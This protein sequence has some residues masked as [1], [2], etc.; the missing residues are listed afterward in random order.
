MGAALRQ[1]LKNT[2]HRWCKWHVL[3]KLVEMLGHL[4]NKHKEF[5]DDFNKVVNHMLSVREFEDSWAA[6]VAKYGL[7]NNPEITRAF[8]SRSMWAK[9]WFKDIFCAR[10][11]STQRSESANNVLKHFVPRNSPLNLFVQQYN[12]LVTEQEKADFDEEQRTK[13][14]SS[15]ICLIFCFDILFSSLLSSSIFLFIAARH[16]VEVWLAY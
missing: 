13:Q 2:R 15:S 7:E 4:F 6:M 11:T 16:Y 12:K 3:K 8:E 14:V 9:A 10:M 5:Q 1:V